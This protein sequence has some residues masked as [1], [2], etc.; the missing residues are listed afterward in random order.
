[1][2]EYIERETF[3]KDIEERYCLPCKEAGKDHNSCK[4]DVCWVDDMSGDV[5]DAPHARCP[6]PKPDNSGHFGLS[7]SCQKRVEELY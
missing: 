1:M 3:L 5:K 6:L 4:C 7:A 2:A